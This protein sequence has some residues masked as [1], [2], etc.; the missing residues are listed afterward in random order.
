MAKII[1][2]NANYYGVSASVNF[3][4]GVGYTS[5]PRLIQ[6]FKENGYTVVEGKLEHQE[7]KLVFEE[8]KQ[9]DEKM[10]E[11]K[12]VESEK[13]KSISKP[14]PNS[15]QTV[16]QKAKTPTRKPQPVRKPGTSTTGKK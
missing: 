4:K 15:D 7:I 10:G 16:S 6:W 11:I 13:P 8:E 12:E 3:V 1:A 2:K 5:D 9:A 14:T